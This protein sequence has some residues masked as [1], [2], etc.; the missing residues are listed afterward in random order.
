MKPGCIW[1]WWLIFS[2]ESY[3]LVNATLDDK[4]H[5]PKR[6]IHGGVAV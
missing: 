1:Q 5:C 3:R 6:I 4:R 2:P